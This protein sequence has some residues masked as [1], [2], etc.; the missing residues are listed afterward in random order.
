LFDQQTTKVWR[1]GNVLASGVVFNSITSE[2]V[3]LGL[4]FFVASLDE[5]EVQ[6]VLT[7]NIGVGLHIV[8]EAIEVR[9][10][11]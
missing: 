7:N 10:E 4:K 1:K 11:I 6:P 2:V 9:G 5:L 8:F 3:K